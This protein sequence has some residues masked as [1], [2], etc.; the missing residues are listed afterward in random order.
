[1]KSSAARELARALGVPERTGMVEAVGAH[2]ALS[3]R[4]ELATSLL[5]RC[6]QAGDLCAAACEMALASDA[7]YTSPGTEPY[8]EQH[9]ALVSCA[10]VC[11]L[12]VKALREGDG[13]LELVRWCAEVCAQCA[14]GQAPEGLP[15]AA[16]MH[17][18][19]ASHRCA[20]EC[21]AVAARISSFTQQAFGR[22]RDSDFHPLAS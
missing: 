13:D 15:E 16:W 10:S 22:R 5:D 19:R 11:S 1:M 12:L 9:L 21:E 8:T 14:G 3:R 4:S 6:I 20:N 2:V 18:V 17:V 7:S